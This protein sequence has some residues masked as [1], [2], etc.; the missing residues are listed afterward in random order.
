MAVDLWNDA[1]KALA[2]PPAPKKPGPGPKREQVSDPV[3]SVPVTFEG[4]VIENFPL[5]YVLQHNN[6]WVYLEV[7]KVYGII[8][9]SWT[10]EQAI[11][12]TGD[13]PSLIRRFTDTLNKAID[14]VLVPKNK[15]YG[16]AKPIL[17]TMVLNLST[18]VNKTKGAAGENSGGDTKDFMEI[19]AREHPK[20]MA[21]VTPNSPLWNTIRGTLL[22]DYNQH[23]TTG[24]IIADAQGRAG[25]MQE[26]NIIARGAQIEATIINLMRA[27]GLFR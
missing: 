17:D 16:Y 20:L 26:K 6:P 25:P 23:G 19:I 9:P 24:G 27:Q 14:T 22:K 5:S 15:Q 13:Q 2:R 7:L 1:D 8:P 10:P 12:A 4:K 3:W 18:L 11:T 21:Q